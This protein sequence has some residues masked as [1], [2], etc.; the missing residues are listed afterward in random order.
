MREA[1]QPHIPIR[2]PRRPEA[3]RAQDDT[4]GATEDLASIDGATV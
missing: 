2:P 3:V 1:H 4:T